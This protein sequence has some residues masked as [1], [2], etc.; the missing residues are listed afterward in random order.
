MLLVERRFDAIAGAALLDHGADVFVHARPYKVACQHL[1]SAV[2]AKV[3]DAG[4]HSANRVWS[5][6]RLGHL[7]GSGSSVQPHLV[8]VPEHGFIINVRSFRSFMVAV[9]SKFAL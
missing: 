9:L 7:T 5:L 6:F 4:V 2:P 8:V 1:V 3:A